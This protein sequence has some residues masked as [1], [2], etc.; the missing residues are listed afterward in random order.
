MSFLGGEVAGDLRLSPAATQ[1]VPYYE[2]PL[3]L[4]FARGGGERRV[5]PPWRYTAAD[6]RRVRGSVR[7]TRPPSGTESVNGE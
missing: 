1:H 5:G 6:A 7:R 3:T 4:S 2:L